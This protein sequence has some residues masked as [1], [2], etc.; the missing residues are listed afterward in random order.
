MGR[1]RSPRL[2]ARVLVERDGRILLVRHAKRKERAF[3]CLPGGNADPGESI[4]AA[5]RR[6]LLEETGV[7]VVV[8]GAVLILDG[9][10]AYTGDGGAVEVILRGRIVA[11]EPGPTDHAG[12][13]YLDRIEWRGLDELPQSFRPAALAALLAAAGS[14]DALPL[15]P[16]AGWGEDD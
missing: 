2:K 9:P 10:D 7:D 6:E 15:I 16:L 4:T 14:A 3:W 11:G 5:A 12:D 1:N 13:P 8:E